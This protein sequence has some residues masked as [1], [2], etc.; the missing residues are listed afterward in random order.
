MLKSFLKTEKI[1]KCHSKEVKSSTTPHIPTN[2]T[3]A[4]IE[5]QGPYKASAK[6]IKALCTGPL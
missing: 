5:N 3:A 1:I 2:I 4:E 6:K